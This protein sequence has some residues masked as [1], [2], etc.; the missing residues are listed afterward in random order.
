MRWRI[1]VLISLLAAVAVAGG[2]VTIEA[3]RSARAAELN[4]AR[5]LRDYA[6]FAAWQY[7]RASSRSLDQAFQSAITSPS[8]RHEPAD[9]ACNCAA[10]KDG[11]VARFQIRLQQP[12][13]W[14]GAPPADTRAREVITANIFAAPAAH[15]EARRTRHVLLSDGGAVAWHIDPGHDTAG[16]VA[17]GILVDTSFLARAFDDA[18]REPLL[19]PSLMAGRD[20]T[21]VLAVRAS[22]ADGRLLFES[23][24]PAWSAD[25]SATAAA[26]GLQLAASV[27]PDAAPEL[28]IGGLPRQRLMLVY[29]LL[30]VAV[31][32]VLIAFRQIHKQAELTRMRADFISGVSHEL[33]TPL[34]QIRMFAETLRLGRVRNANESTHAL[35]VILQE[36]QRLTRL[37][38]KV[39]TFARG[40]RAGH[41]L[42]L[43][44]VS[45]SDFAREAAADLQPLA[46]SRSATLTTAIEHGIHAEVDVHALRQVVV[47]LVDNAFKYG[48]SGQS[49]T[50]GLRRRG[51]HAELWVEDEGPGI[52][53]TDAAHIWKPFWRRAKAGEGGSGIGLAIVSDLVR[54]HGGAVSLD[55]S[56]T[57]GARFVVTVPASAA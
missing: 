23:R 50:L 21:R 20:L 57:G 31:A 42:S 44:P 4:A 36:S 56:S 5:V 49:V 11:I 17:H 22:T 37:V 51:D 39:L 55:A 40:E 18:A 24:E 46:A 53:E 35:D 29:A 27:T 25:T 30:G 12:R 9:P 10:E 54:L 38:D 33:R 34:A 7:A 41:S 16:A 2:V 48:P 43:A 15:G 47:N 8:G 14:I 45:L 19:P 32:L 13:E 28:I 1:W 3:R 52:P 26:D 6:A